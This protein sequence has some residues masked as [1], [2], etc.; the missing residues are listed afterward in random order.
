MKDHSKVT[1]IDNQEA[2]SEAEKAKEA[3]KALFRNA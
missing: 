2:L 3:F 1:S